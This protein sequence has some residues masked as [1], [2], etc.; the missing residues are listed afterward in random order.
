MH[1]W[2]FFPGGQTRDIVLILQSVDYDR[3]VKWSMEKTWTRRYAALGCKQKLSMVRSSARVCVY[4]L[5]KNHLN[6]S[7]LRS[8]IFDEKT[9]RKKKIEYFWQK[10]E[11]VILY[12]GMFDDKIK[13]IAL[14]YFLRRNSFRNFF[15]F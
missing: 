14:P 8:R 9:T 4:S 1:R 5:A 10:N 7:S 11:G 13:P 3:K 15:Q 12:G 2:Y 6:L